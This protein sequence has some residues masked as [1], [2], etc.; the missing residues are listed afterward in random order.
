MKLTKGKV[1]GLA[2]A[3]FGALIGGIFDD[4]AR[5]AEIKEAVEEYMAAKEKREAKQE[6]KEVD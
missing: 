4:F 1:I 3:A 2:C 6:D 5:E